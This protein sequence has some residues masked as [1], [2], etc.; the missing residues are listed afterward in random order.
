[1]TE[2]E[3]HTNYGIILNPEKEYPVSYTIK[4]DGTIVKE[5]TM[6]LA[7]DMTE[8]QVKQYL[9]YESFILSARDQFAIGFAEWMEDNKWWKSTDNRFPETL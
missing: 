8:N 3:K 6:L 2:Q 9:H 4:Q 1:M 5:N 7:Q